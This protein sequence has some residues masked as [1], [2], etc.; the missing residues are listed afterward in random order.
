MITQSTAQSEIGSG[1]RVGGG[2]KRGSVEK[3]SK[4]A[5]GARLLQV[6]MKNLLFLQKLLPEKD[7][8]RCS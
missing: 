7:T 4:K 5:G 3:T 6:R 8:L 2:V 1:Q